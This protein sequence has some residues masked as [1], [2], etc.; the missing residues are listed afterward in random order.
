MVINYRTEV[1]PLNHFALCAK[2]W[3]E[4]VHFSS[5]DQNIRLFEELKSVLALDGYFTNYMNIKDFARVIVNSFENY[6]K[7][8]QDNDLHYMCLTEFLD[9]IKHYESCGYGYFESIIMTVRNFIQYSNKNNIKLNPPV[10]SRKLYKEYDLI[11]GKLCPVVKHRQTYKEMNAF[12][13]KY[14]WD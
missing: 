10:Y 11:M 7:W 14:K 12:V 2:G 8:C 9:T 13:K 3:Y 5:E 4:K 1:F 6:N